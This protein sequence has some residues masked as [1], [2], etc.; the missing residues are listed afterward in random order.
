MLSSGGS[1]NSAY[2]LVREMLYQYTSYNESVALSSL[3]VYYLEPNTRITIK[4]SDSGIFGDYIINSISLPL[5]I[6]G[7]MNISCIRAVEKI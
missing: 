2:N 1:L 4:D 5:G 3:P 6:T 7:T